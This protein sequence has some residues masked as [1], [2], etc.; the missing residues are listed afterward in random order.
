MAVYPHAGMPV[1]S[2]PWVRGPEAQHDP[3]THG[4][5]AGTPVSS[6]RGSFGQ[7]APYGGRPMSSGQSFARPVNAPSATFGATRPAPSYGA[8]VYGRPS[9]S[10]AGH[11]SAG[12]NLSFAPHPGYQPPAARPFAQPARPA[13]QPQSM[14]AFAPAPHAFTPAAQQ[15]RVPRVQRRRAVRRRQQLP[16][17][18]W[19]RSRGWRLPSAGGWRVPAAGG[20]RRLSRPVRRWF[21]P[22]GRLGGRRQPQARSAAAPT[23]A[24][25]APTT[26]DTDPG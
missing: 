16:I 25:A 26:A 8:P 1:Y 4:W 13:Y 19:R 23:S 22:A 10:F 14:R 5:R 21:P 11:P 2:R 20:R 7:V 12:A 6:S 24:A 15:R 18:R 3:L 17:V 9:P